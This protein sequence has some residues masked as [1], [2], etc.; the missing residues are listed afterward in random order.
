NTHKTISVRTLLMDMFHKLMGNSKAVGAGLRGMPKG[1]RT[2]DLVP[3]RC[4]ARPIQWR[5][6]ETPPY[7]VIY[8]IGCI[9]FG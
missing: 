7:D 3:A 2:V 9:N 8:E 6:T 1:I 5:G 4:L